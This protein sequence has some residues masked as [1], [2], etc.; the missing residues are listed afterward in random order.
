MSFNSTRYHVDKLA[1]AGEIIRVD[2]GGY[3]RL[4]PTG[5]NDEERALFAIARSETDRKILSN[6]VID[7]VLSNKQL[8]D[9]TGLAKSTISEHITELVRTGVIKTRQA[10]ET[11]VSYEL[12]QPDRIRAILMSL[13]RSLRRK[14]TDRFI[15]LWD[16]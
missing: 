9:R 13:N 2:D 8:C 15:D 5:T 11:N 10:G 14:A 7:V 3:S 12:E 6:L 16:F 4:Y 1:K